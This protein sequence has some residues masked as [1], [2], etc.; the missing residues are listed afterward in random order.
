MPQPNIF[1]VLKR[2]VSMKWFFW[3]PKK[4]MLKLIDKKIF[5]ILLEKIVYLN[6]RNIIFEIVLL[7]KYLGIVVWIHSTYESCFLRRQ[8]KYDLTT[9]ISKKMTPEGC[10]VNFKLNLLISYFHDIYWYLQFIY[11]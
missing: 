11:T 3:T 10:N 2:T 5:T 1:V 4:H 9:F 7:Q 6:L 8:W